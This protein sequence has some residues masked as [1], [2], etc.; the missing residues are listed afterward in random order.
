[1]DMAALLLSS[2]AQDL[3]RTISKAARAHGNSRPSR[4]RP[5]R[6]CSRLWAAWSP[7]RG[8]LGRDGCSW[9]L[10]FFF[11]SSGPREETRQWHLRIRALGPEHSGGSR[12]AAR[13]PGEHASC[14]RAS[15]A[16]CR[17]SSPGWPAQAHGLPPG[18][19]TAPRTSAPGSQSP[20]P[21]AVRRGFQAPR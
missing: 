9:S 10:G 20:R 5:F 2:S 6:L 3:S 7:D 14:R 17:P 11:P 4:P 8:R 1:M 21:G 16:L 18:P 19:C 15:C 12:R 13:S